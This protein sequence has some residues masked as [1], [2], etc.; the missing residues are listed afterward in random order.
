[1]PSHG[2]RILPRRYEDNTSWNQ[3]LADTIYVPYTGATGNVDLGGYNI[4]ANSVGAGTAPITPMHIKGTLRIEDSA[5][6]SN[7]IEIQEQAAGS[8]PRG[9]II[10]GDDVGDTNWGIKFAHAYSSSALNKDLLFQFSTNKDVGYV[11]AE[12]LSFYARG[13]GRHSIFSSTGPGSNGLPIEIHT[14]GDG[15]STTPNLFLD[16]A[17]NGYRVGI[18]TDNPFSKLSFADTDGVT[19]LNNRIALYESSAGH[20]FYGI[21]MAQPSDYGVGLWASTGGSLP[22]DSNMDLFVEATSGD[23]GI[24]TPNPTQRLN[25]VG[26]SNV[27]ENATF[28]KDV[29]ING[30]LFGG[31]PL[32]IGDD[33]NIAGDLDVVNINPTGVITD[34]TG[35]GNFIDVT[36]IGAG[37]DNFMFTA[38]AGA[39]SDAVNVAGWWQHF[40]TGVGG[41]VYIPFY[42]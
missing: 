15:L 10:G 29:I 27:T 18:A 17:A 22:T 41:S 13:S 12:T 4:T 25:V 40:E 32:D 9:L 28:G 2:R 19:V 36:A 6:V 37:S 7:I 26:D 24:N 30:I 20:Y 33:T 39:P 11:N 8:Y 16:T 21:G 3:T 14:E 34:M 42:V 5:D 35:A 31:S 38:S 1:M 23:V